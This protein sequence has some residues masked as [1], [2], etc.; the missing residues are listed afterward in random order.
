MSTCRLLTIVVLFSFSCF[1]ENPS[2]VLSFTDQVYEVY[3]IESLVLGQRKYI[4]SKYRE[5]TGETQARMI[6]FRTNKMDIADIS[7]ILEVRVVLA[8]GKLPWEVQQL[9]VTCQLEIE[10]IRNAQLAIAQEDISLKND[11]QILQ[12]FMIARRVIPN[13]RALP[14]ER[15]QRIISFPEDH[16][17]LSSIK[18]L[19]RERLLHPIATYS[20]SKDG[21]LDV[22]VPEASISLVTAIRRA[23]EGD[24]GVGREMR[25]AEARDADAS[26]A[27]GP[28][29]GG[30]FKG[31]RRVRT[32]R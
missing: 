11:P 23:I 13:E 2:P 20:V 17:T 26:R 9:L 6:R 10:A 16:P 7:T 31:L 21:I 3:Y 19:Q 28:R 8:D 25:A 32:V 24:S 1:A 27:E 5:G 18:V 12:D 22:K 4:S 14:V 29:E 15:I 30:R